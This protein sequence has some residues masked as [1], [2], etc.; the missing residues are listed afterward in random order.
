MVFRECWRASES[1]AGVAS[2]MRLPECKPQGIDLRRFWNIP[3]YNC[4][5]RVS[6]NGTTQTWPNIIS[7]MKWQMVEVAKWIVP[8]QLADEGFHISSRL[9]ALFVES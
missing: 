8:L 6:D 2:Y 3:I 9:M 5:L 4:S 7:R 1:A